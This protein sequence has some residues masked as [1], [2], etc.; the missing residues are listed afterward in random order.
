[1][2]K[3]HLKADDVSKRR[4]LWVENGVFSFEKVVGDVDAEDN[5]RQHLPCGLFFG[6]GI[7][8]QM[9]ADEGEQHHFEQK[10]GSTGHDDAVDKV[11]FGGGGGV[12]GKP[13]QQNQGNQA[14]GEPANEVGGHD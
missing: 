11:V 6:G 12:E 9:G 7:L 2:A 3:G 8:A 4:F 14:D 1:M 13:N 5:W 10:H